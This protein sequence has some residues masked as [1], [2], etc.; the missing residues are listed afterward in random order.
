MAAQLNIK[1]ETTILLARR[2]AEQ[3][4]ESVTATI[5]TALEQAAQSREA[6]IQR[7]I[8]AIKKISADFRRNMP[9]GW[10]GKTSK[11]I[12]DEIYDEDGLPI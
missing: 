11:E 5:R 12:M 2:L 8:K 9:A 4:G 7:K 1:D 6:E 3:S 10:H